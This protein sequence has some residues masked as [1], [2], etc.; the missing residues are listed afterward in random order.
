MG[1][2]F[3]MYLREELETYAEEPLPLQVLLHVLREYKR[4][5]D[6]INELVKKEELTPLKRGLYIPGPNLN[7]SRPESFLI[8][9]HLRGPSYVSIETALAY[10]GYI[11]ERVYEISSATTKTAK[12]Y[13]TAAGRFSYFKVPLPY[14][15][16][17]ITRVVLSDRQAV[18]FAT[19]E[20]A[21]CDKIIFTP[22]V[23]L[24]SEKQTR[25]FLTDD[26][27]IDEEM[28]QQLETETIASWISDAPKKTSLRMLVKTL[29]Q[30]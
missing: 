14:Y 29:E 20:K 21:L 28:L 2:Y 16:F 30:L 27:R 23:L 8:A 3:T 4:P 19:P 24:R 6:K 18:M 26:L 12:V 22:G 9:N 11:P 17:G 7:I 13:T 10:W 1:K 15:S 25:E 5:Y